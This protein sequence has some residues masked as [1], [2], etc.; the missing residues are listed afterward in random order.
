MAHWVKNLPAKQETREMWV[1]SLSR[2]KEMASHSGT[3]A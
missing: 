2:G 1:P 3:L